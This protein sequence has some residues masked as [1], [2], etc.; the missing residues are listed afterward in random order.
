MSPKKTNQKSPRE[1]AL[2]LLTVRDRFVAELEGRLRREGFSE[3]EVADTI[4]WLRG[5][6]YLDD[7]KTAQMWVQHRNRFRI[8]GNLGLRYE[9]STK[10]AEDSVIN[11]VLNSRDAERELAVKAA[12]RKLQLLSERDDV[13]RRRQ[14]LLQFLQRRG[15][16]W[17]VAAAAADE[18]LGDS[19]DSDP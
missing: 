4:A 2:R 5:L 12:Q 18:T 14:K 8:T 6:G 10:G 7:R 13:L 16:T 19:L 1:R 11:E 9:L 3:D 15:F 17:D